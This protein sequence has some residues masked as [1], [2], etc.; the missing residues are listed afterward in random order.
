MSCFMPIR[1]WIATL[2]NSKPLELPTMFDGAQRARS[3]PHSG[4]VL[5]GVLFWW[6]LLWVAWA[7]RLWHLD[8][9]DL[10]FDEAATFFVADRPL[11][12]ILTYLRGAVREHPPLYYLL[13][14]AWMNLAGSSEYSLRFFAAGASMVGIALTARLARRVARQLAIT[15]PIEI[16]LAVSLPALIMALLPFEVYYA[17]DAR[18]Y[19]LTV[20]WATLSALL[21]LSLI[22]DQ[23]RGEWPS[24]AKLGV[25]VLVNCLAVF[26]HFYLVLLV[27]TQFVVLLILRRW[28][29]WLAWCAAHGLV[30]L[31]GLVWLLRSPGLTSSLKE[32]W[33]RFVPVWPTLGQLRRLLADLLFG[34]IRGVPWRLVYGWAVLVALGVLALWLRSARA[35]TEDKRRQVNTIGVWLTATLLLPIALAY[36]M[37]EPPRS[38]YL[39]YLLPFA[40]LAVGQIPFIVTGQNKP[41]LVWLVLSALIVASLGVFGLP[42]TV[43]WIKSDYGRTVEAVVDH[44]RPGDAV[45]FYG[46]WQ[47]LQFHYYRPESF[48][49][50]TRLPPQA[51]PRLNPEEAKPVLRDLLSTY[52]RLWVMPASVEDVDPAHFVTG[53][54]NA[55]AHPVWTGHDLS[56]YIAPSEHDT[57]SLPTALTF[58]GQLRLERVASD[59]Q[60]VPAGESL[61]LTLTWAVSDTLDS[62]FTLDF[63]LVDERGDRWLQWQS[64]PGRW[65]NPPSTWESGDAVIDRQGVIVP[66]GAP[67]GS[68]TIQLTVL[69]RASGAPLPPA[70]VQGALSEANADLITFEV[71]EPVAPPIF[72]DAGDFVGPF[73]FESPLPTD[74]GLTLAGYDLGGLKFTQGNPVPLWLHWL[75]PAEP[76]PDLKLRLQLVY[77]SRGDPDDIGAT[78]PNGIELPLITG[79]PVGEWQSGRMVSLPTTVGIP[80]DAPAGRADLTLSVV[81]PDGQPWTIDGD[82]YL[83]LGTLTV[84]QRPIARKLPDGLTA[85]RVDYADA[86]SGTGDQ[87]GLRGYRVEGEA[88][89]G[90]SLE[91]TYGWHALSQP[92]RIYSVFNHLLTVDGQQVAQTDG[93]PQDGIVLTNQWQPGEYVRDM[94]VLEIPDDAPSGPYVLTV[95]LYDAA[96]GDRLQAFSDGQPLPG[97]QWQLRVGDE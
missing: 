88:L 73:D 29:L 4:L 94:H 67:P 56:L 20:V 9:S 15:A 46:P 66:Q 85:V 6:S 72:A 18:M 24:R 82:Q 38:R 84:E 16:F 25:L 97:N 5:V 14:R 23:R 7:V 21:F 86:T 27:A 81:G 3:K 35:D 2:G 77:G 8:A 43:Q 42:R 68:Y 52:Q 22:G 57:V 79:Y 32:A 28:R 75:A 51:P 36:F 53:W 76:L 33:G 55:N 69:D 45:L 63:S 34:P 64:V 49:P 65:L 37:P 48:P 70:D 95:G 80:P 11:L 40:A 26:T 90:G 93:W 61:R 91:L 30:V 59:A 47:A 13:I 89:P 74:D 50:I 87:I 60:A 44:A 96:S 41:A 39:I 62:D 83:T 92:T 54:L 31:I 17:R 58:G 19:T 71:V 1:S 78:S 10:T 12:D